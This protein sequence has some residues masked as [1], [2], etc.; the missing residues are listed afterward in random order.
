MHE[1]ILADVFMY[2]LGAPSGPD[3]PIFKRLRSQWSK[4]DKTKFSAASGD[5][6]NGSLC[7]LRDE[8]TT[9]YIATLEEGRFSRDDYA[10]LLHLSLVF[11]G[12]VPNRAIEFRAPG[13]LHQARWM[14]KA[15]YALKIYLFREQIKLTSREQKGL[16]NI[17][18]FVALMY[19]KY[20]HKA[21]LPTQ[22]A[23]ND[24][25][26]MSSLMS[27]PNQPIA[28]VAIKALKRHLWYFAEELIGLEFFD[29]SLEHGTKKKMTENLQLPARAKGL[30]RLDGKQFVATTTLD[31][32]VTEKTA[33]IFDVLL[34][35]GKQLAAETFLLLEP[36]QWAD[37]PTYK[38]F[39][40][41]ARQ[42]KVVNDCAERG[43]ALILQYNQTL[44]KDETQKQYLLRV[45]NIHRKRYPIPSKDT[46][47]RN[48]S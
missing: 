24:Q 30:K 27:Y 45:V 44:T 5:L 34:D 26:F 48:S 14:A 41:K 39:L 16:E 10:E 13:A 31:E 1:I 15:I 22:A 23:R 20:W 12:G 9:F 32:Y 46:L 8:M 28:K 3:I 36:S 7:E 21:P 42:M 40:E 2:V 4:I 35:N 29:E 47:A 33:N 37:E 6:F 25:A 11:L 18:L 38:L 17:C 19:A 43:I